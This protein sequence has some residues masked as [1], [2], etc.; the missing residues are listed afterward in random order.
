[1]DH[2]YALV[3]LLNAKEVTGLDV[4]IIPKEFNR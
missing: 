1:M 4:S 2:V 3:S